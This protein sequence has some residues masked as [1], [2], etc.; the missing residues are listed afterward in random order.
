MNT[1]PLS[2]PTSPPCAPKA[3]ETWK[4]WLLEGHDAKYV[5]AHRLMRR[6][7]A[8]LFC[9]HRSAEDRE[10][11]G[12]APGQQQACTPAPPGVP[13]SPAND[14]CPHTPRLAR[15]TSQ[16]V[17][18]TSD[19]G[20]KECDTQQ[21]GRDT[22]RKGWQATLRAAHNS[23]RR[24][25]DEWKGAFNVLAPDAV[26]VVRGNFEPPPVQPKLPQLSDVR[27]NFAE[28][29]A[30][31]EA[32][33]QREAALDAA[34]RNAQERLDAAKGFADALQAGRSRQVRDKHLV[35]IDEVLSF[36][37]P[38][39]TVLAIMH[40]CTSLLHGY[41][42]DLQKLTYFDIMKLLSS[43]ET[44]AAALRPDVSATTFD[45][46]AAW[47]RN[48]LCHYNIFK[49]PPKCLKLLIAAYGTPGAYDLRLDVETAKKSSAA[50]GLFAEWYQAQF[51]FWFARQAR[52]ELPDLMPQLKSDARAARAALE[53]AE[54]AHCQRQATADAA[55]RRQ[56][57]ATALVQEALGA[58]A[59]ALQLL[60]EQ[61]SGLFF[62]D[63]VLPSP[64]AADKRTGEV[65]ERK[66]QQF[67]QHSSSISEALP[68]GTA[69]IIRNNLL[70]WR[71]QLLGFIGD[72]K[73]SA[74]I[75]DALA[76]AY[77]RSGGQRVSPR[78][79]MRQ[80]ATSTSQDLPGNGGGMAQEAAATA[81]KTFMAPRTPP[82]PLPTVT[83][84]E[85]GTDGEEQD[86][87]DAASSAAEP[88]EATT[89]G[90]SPPRLLPSTVTTTKIGH[91][92]ASVRGLTA[93]VASSVHGVQHQ[94]RQDRPSTFRVTA[95][96][97][98]RAHWQ[99]YF[100][101]RTRVP[102]KPMPPPVHSPVKPQKRVIP[103]HSDNRSDTESWPVKHE[104]YDARLPEPPP[105]PPLRP[106]TVSSACHLGRLLLLRCDRRICLCCNLA[107]AVC[108]VAG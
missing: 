100:W 32:A 48:R 91:F 90:V 40:A 104:R 79:R 13:R 101:A 93:V 75:T 106:P 55:S 99:R 31:L 80:A 73:A 66:G 95:R 74:R 56:A 76:S 35:W 58:N 51:G 19:G 14:S 102:I 54:Q 10:P 98:S 9:S 12:H 34:V 45:D 11:C 16:H 108:A 62:P 44:A 8:I 1:I 96:A 72:T 43:D 25:A 37:A 22:C 39:D 92:S 50:I 18:S 24:A 47:I 83:A 77:M 60:R 82:P 6:R 86:G 97:M 49:C 41:Y 15:R 78:V 21:K 71:S 61:V 59:A 64:T 3:E 84:G 68:A 36:T 81:A 30:S 103:R 5:A 26:S 23:A 38:T 105:H 70:L 53:A 42:I 63:G 4:D 94:H 20:G 27:Q 46:T 57:A 67:G 29:H 65:E 85:N 89:G 33:R 88:C 52:A 28:A 87:A 7:H 2:P 17:A 107:T 69:A